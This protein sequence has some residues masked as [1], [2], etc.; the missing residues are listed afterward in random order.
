[1]DVVGEVGL[2]AHDALNDA[3]NTACICTHLDMHKALA[4]YHSFGYQMACRVPFPERNDRPIITFPTREAAIEDPELT[5]IICPTCGADVICG[6]I[7]RQKTNKFICIGECE[8]GHE[9]F[10]RLK[11][12]RWHDGTFSARRLLYAADEE[13]KAYYLNKKRQNEEEKAAYLQHKALV[14]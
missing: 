12:S 13:N 10:V 3:M 8:M 9:L 5:S 11:I 7:A 14:E 4:E 2:K 1:M 6:D